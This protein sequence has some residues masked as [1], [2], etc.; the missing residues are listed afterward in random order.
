[1]IL[2]ASLL[3][4][5]A[6][7][8]SKVAAEKTPVVISHQGPLYWALPIYI[9]GERGYFEQLMLDPSF[10][11]VSLG[12]SLQLANGILGTSFCSLSVSPLTSH[13]L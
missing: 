3:L 4:S 7:W 5:L 8:T 2:K 13:T 1:M 12:Y 10:E 6:L 11:V 9:A